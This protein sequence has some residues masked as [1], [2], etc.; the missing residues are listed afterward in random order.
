M[1]DPEIHLERS[2]AE[3]ECPVV[4]GAPAILSP[5][6]RARVN[7]ETYFFSSTAAMERFV[8]DPLSYCG[9][10]TDPVSQVRFVPTPDSPRQDYAG[11]PYFFVSE[12][13]R[14]CFI[15]SPEMWADANREMPEG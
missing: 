2:G 10:L 7:H 8:A 1:Q 9:T 15:E 3:L 12:E 5:D 6:L 14:R 4:P 13:T 11:R